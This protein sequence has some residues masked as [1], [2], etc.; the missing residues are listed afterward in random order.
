MAV[1]FGMIKEF[2]TEIDKRKG[3][4]EQIEENLSEVKK[5]KDKLKRRQINIEQ[6]QKIIQTVAKQTQQELE[7]HISELVS[8]AL[9][10]VFDDPYSL[11][12]EFVEKRGK[13]E[14]EIT[15]ER[16]G[17]KI[18]PI[19]A[20]GG[21]AVDV[22]SFALRVAL[23]NLRRRATRNTIVLDE[24]M[25]FLSKNLLPKAG[26]MIKELSEKLGLQFII[27]SHLKELVDSADKVFEIDI[28]KGISNVKEV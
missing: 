8:L 28:K 1:N 12:L 23:W 10:A 9:S 6:A 19:Q 13:T 25:K 27:V 7:Y 5:Q 18:S 15:F 22:A 4:K 3:K 24:P 16:A 14:A 20:S 17:E 2:R 11:N 21:G 26:E